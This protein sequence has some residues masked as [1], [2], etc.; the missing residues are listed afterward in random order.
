MSVSADH[1]SLFSKKMESREYQIAVDQHMAGAP[2]GLWYYVIGR[3]RESNNWK[4]GLNPIKHC[5]FDSFQSKEGLYFWHCIEHKYWNSALATDFWMEQ[6]KRDV[7]WVANEIL[8]KHQLWLKGEG[9]ECAN[10]SEKNFASKHLQG[11]NLSRANLYRTN[12][13]NSNLS[14]SNLSE[15]E[16]VEADLSWC[17]LR[18]SDLSGCNLRGANLYG[19]N[20]SLANLNNAHINGANIE[21]V[22]IN[23]T[24]GFYQFGPSIKK[25]IICHAVWHDG[26]WMVNARLFA[27]SDFFWGTL[28]ELEKELSETENDVCE[29]TMANIEVLRKF[30]TVSND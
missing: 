10:L 18:R 16:L 13:S 15:A 28:S 6:R 19:A 23:G 17:D 20:L 11:V 2:H 9:G 29:M 4:E 27:N 26:K 7:S 21:W 5:G 25:R 3:L 8:D 1:Q 30:E 24:L 14:W 12:F 22:N